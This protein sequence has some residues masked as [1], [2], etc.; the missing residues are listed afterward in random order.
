M[1]SPLLSLL[2]NASGEGAIKVLLP[3]SATANGQQEDSTLGR[4]AVAPGVA[5]QL[6]PVPLPDPWSSTQPYCSIM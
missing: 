5:G 2:G 1:Q 3:N 6:N 4:A